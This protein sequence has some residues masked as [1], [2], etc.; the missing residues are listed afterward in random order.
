M[1]EKEKLFNK[2]NYYLNNK[3][4]AIFFPDAFQVKERFNLF[5]ITNNRSF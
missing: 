4:L 5:I 2:K 3:Y 1:K